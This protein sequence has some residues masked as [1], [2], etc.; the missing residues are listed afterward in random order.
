MA[1]AL[2]IPHPTLGEAIVLGAVPTEGHSLDPEA[3]RAFLKERL[4][5]Y[6]VQRHV[7]VFREA[8]VSFTGTRKLQ[9]APLLE[10][11]QARLAAEGVVIAGY[12]YGEEPGR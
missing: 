3:L 11:A 4:A 1:A 9:V 6:K 10:R 2:G 8:D 12:R 5:A 7:L